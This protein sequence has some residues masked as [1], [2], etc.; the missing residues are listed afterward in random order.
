MEDVMKYGGNG[1]KMQQIFL[2]K[3]RR[4]TESFVRRAEALGFKGIVVTI[5]N[6]V[7]GKRVQDLRNGLTIPPKVTDRL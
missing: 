5:D 2:W 4:V 6:N 7:N 3:D 1:P